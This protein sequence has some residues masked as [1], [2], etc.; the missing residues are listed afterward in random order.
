MKQAGAE[1]GQTK[2]KICLA[3]KDA[4]VILERNQICAKMTKKNKTILS[5]NWSFRAKNWPKVAK[6]NNNKNK[7]FEFEAK[8]GAK[9]TKK[10]R[11]FKAK[12]GA[13]NWQKIAKKKKKKN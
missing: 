1:R 5:Q 9:K 11:L 13:K 7:T 6:K 4:D 12:I 3:G 8:T 10:T 2:C